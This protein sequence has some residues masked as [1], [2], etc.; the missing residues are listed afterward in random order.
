MTNWRDSVLQGTKEAARLQRDLGLESKIE[1]TPGSIDVFA[2]IVQLN[3]PLLFEPLQG[4]LGAY[5]PKPV[6]GI[7]VSTERNLSIQRF[8]GAHELGHAYM[9][10]EG[11][12]DDQSILERAPFGSR[13]YDPNEAAADAFAASFLI[14][15]WL[16]EIHAGRHKWNA[17]S[18]LD[19]VTA[20]Q[21]SLR[22]GASYDATCRSLK[23]YGIVDVHGVEKLLEI[24]PKKIKQHILDGSKLENWY[25][26]VWV[27][28]ESDGN[29]RIQ[30]GPNDIFVLRLREKSGAGYLWNLEDLEAAGFAIVTDT[31]QIPSEEQQ[32]GGVVDRVLT[33][34]LS[35][36][37]RGHSGRISLN[38]VRPWAPSDQPME[39]LTLI[40][41]LFGKEAG[42]PRVRRSR[43]AAA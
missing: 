38:Q 8:T 41:D 42:L 25:P 33:A 23:H 18:L 9:K 29:T 3:I 12:L 28:T 39:S 16:L 34:R 17:K 1:Q 27:L 36:Q 22:V 35:E 5:L 4:L 37:D 19:P 6:P 31:R 11:S 7:L 13:S 2:A 24:Q 40:Y 30:G 20:Y 43:L 26:D 10:H 21:M 15:R 14:P 32:I